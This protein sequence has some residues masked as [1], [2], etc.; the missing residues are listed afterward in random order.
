V[1]DG[2]DL[3]DASTSMKELQEVQRLADEA[4][5]FDEQMWEG[6]T[7][8]TP[9]AGTELTEL[10]LRQLEFA[11]LALAG[12]VG[13][14]ANLVKRTRRTTLKGSEVDPAWIEAMKLE[15]ADV[16]A[17]LL[18]LSNVMRWD[19]EALYREKMSRNEA[20]FGSLNATRPEP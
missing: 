16:L 15:T 18:K 12:E 10:D 17:Y 7:S 11:T 1:D 5:G 20:R 14:L 8:N 3:Y 2:R 19:L 13:E 6:S 4:W 9:I